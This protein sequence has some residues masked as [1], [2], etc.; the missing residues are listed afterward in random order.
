MTQIQEFLH[1]D[2]GFGNKSL[3]VRSFSKINNFACNLG[4]HKQKVFLINADA[5]QNCH[6]LHKLWEISRCNN[7]SSTAHNNFFK[8]L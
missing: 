3:K 8:S 5:A 7:D 2:Y 6:C 1:F 4:N